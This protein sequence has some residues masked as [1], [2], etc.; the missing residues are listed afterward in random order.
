MSKSAAPDS[1]G[2]TRYGNLRGGAGNAHGAEALAEADSSVLLTAIASVL[3]A[4]DA[5]LF[6]TTRDGGAVAMQLFSGDT[7]DKVYAA[8]RPELED[9]LRAITAAATT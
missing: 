4:G 3:L 7:T 9:A 8:S 1:T 5:I 6:G 2:P